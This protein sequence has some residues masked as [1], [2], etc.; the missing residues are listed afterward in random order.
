MHPDVGHRQG[1]V[2][3]ERPRPID[4]N[5]LGFLA[6]M[7][8]P[9]Q[10]VPAP[11]AH[12]V[13]FSADY[14]ARQKILYVRPRFHN[15]PDELVPYHHRHRYGLLRPGVPFIDVNVGPA[16][17]RAI[18]PDQHVV[19]A[20]LRR[21]HVFQPKPRFCFSFDQC[22]HSRA[23]TW[24][25]INRPHAQRCRG[26]PARRGQGMVFYLYSRAALLGHVPGPGGQ[27]PAAPLEGRLPG[28]V[29]PPSRESRGPNRF[30]PRNCAGWIGRR[31]SR[32]APGAIRRSPQSRRAWGG[33]RRSRP[34]SEALLSSRAG[35]LEDGLRSASR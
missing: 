33:E 34:D 19:Q 7:P 16:D 29:S 24:F 1:Q 28:V 18:D 22:F 21:R 35:P 8:P 17:P 2:L 32:R 26:F 12:H 31:T 6:Q 11:P 13:P 5:A 20:N 14:L 15:L 23:F 3:R 25:N 10:A 30:S 9:R 4:P 27:K